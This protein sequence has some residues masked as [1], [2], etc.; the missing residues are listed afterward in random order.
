MPENNTL[1]LF[2]YLNH[3][4]SRKLYFLLLETF[5]E[6]QEPKRLGEL[7]KELLQKDSRFD[8]LRTRYLANKLAK[9]GL[10]FK[11]KEGHAVFYGITNL[12]IKVLKIAQ[13]E[14]NSWAWDF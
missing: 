10:L 3:S 14:R 4:L 6:H 2:Y 11:I 5:N 1:S 13:A 9:L 8:E 12:G 7:R